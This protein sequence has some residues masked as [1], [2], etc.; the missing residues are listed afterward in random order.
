MEQGR[1]RCRITNYK[2]EYSTKPTKV[3]LMAVKNTVEKEP[4]LTQE[5]ISLLK[6]EQNLKKQLTQFK[7]SVNGK[8]N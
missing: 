5:E 7:K 8:T 1:R 6:F 3:V 2:L 4:T